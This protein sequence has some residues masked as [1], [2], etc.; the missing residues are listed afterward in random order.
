MPSSTVVLT[1]KLDALSIVDGVPHCA[2]WEYIT[3]IF[4][5]FELS[6]Q[7]LWS[8]MGATSLF[9]AICFSGRGLLRY[10]LSPTTSD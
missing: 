3:P 6:Q 5:M 2:D 10:L 8:V 4:P 7:E 1:C 9:L